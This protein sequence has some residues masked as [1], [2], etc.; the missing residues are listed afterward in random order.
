MRMCSG[1][2]DGRAVSCL[3]RLPHLDAAWAERNSLALLEQRAEHVLADGH[4]AQPVIELAHKGH[5]RQDIPCMRAGTGAAWVHIWVDES[6]RCPW[7][8]WTVQVLQPPDGCMCACGKQARP[9]V[10]Q[11]LAGEDTPYG[12]M[13]YMCASLCCGA[14]AVGVVEPC[15]RTHRVRRMS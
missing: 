8:H 7:L 12:W 6:T 4:E 15:T 2:L 1:W 3:E 10:G 9:A 5:L 14:G 13:A 11:E